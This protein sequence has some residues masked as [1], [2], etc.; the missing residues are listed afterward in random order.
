MAGPRRCAGRPVGARGRATSWARGDLHRQNMHQQDDHSGVARPDQIIRI[1]ITAAADL[2]I[3]RSILAGG[4]VAD[5]E[6]SGG[7]GEFVHLQV[8]E[9]LGQ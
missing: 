1:C 5:G 2:E 3:R 9:V 7:E 8:G 6:V 4:G